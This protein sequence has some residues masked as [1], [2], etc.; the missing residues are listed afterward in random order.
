M[1]RAALRSFHDLQTYNAA[2]IGYHIEYKFAKEN[3]NKT[4]PK[5]LQKFRLHSKIGK[6]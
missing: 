4:K 1:R 6:S 3:T 2:V 5:K